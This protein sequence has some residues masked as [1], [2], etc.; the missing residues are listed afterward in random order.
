MKR[1]Q[2][3]AMIMGPTVGL[4]AVAVAQPNVGWLG[5]ADITPNGLYIASATSQDPLW[6]AWYF[7]NFVG[8]LTSPWDDAAYPGTSLPDGYFHQ[9]I[10]LPFCEEGLAFMT[11]DIEAYQGSWGTVDSGWWD[12]EY[13][14]CSS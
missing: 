9:T 2:L 1:M 7:T 10:I 4:P 14:T 8:H 12:L 11:S 6:H 5:D 13:V 3:A